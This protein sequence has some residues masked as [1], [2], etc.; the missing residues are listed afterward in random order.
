MIIYDNL[1]YNMIEYIKPTNLWYIKPTISTGPDY[2]FNG[3]Y[4]WWLQLPWCQRA[5]LTL[6][7]STRRSNKTQ[8]VYWH[9]L[10][11]AADNFFPAGDLHSLHLRRRILRYWCRPCARK[12]LQ[13]AACLSGKSWGGKKQP[14]R[15]AI[16]TKWDWLKTA[17]NRS[18]EDCSKPKMMNMCGSIPYSWST[19]MGS[20][21]KIGYHKVPLNPVAYHH[22]HLYY[23]HCT[24]HFQHFSTRFIQLAILVA[25]QPIDPDHRCHVDRSLLRR[26][27]CGP[28]WRGFKSWRRRRKRLENWWA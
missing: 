9:V 23:H 11:T 17:A 13:S 27:V 5:S 7:Q 6:P 24:R 22:Y 20:V 8:A 1:W 14:L 19:T 25:N 15:W 12:G 16:T 28:W 3:V 18:I 4:D 10:T 26:T 21:W 2:F